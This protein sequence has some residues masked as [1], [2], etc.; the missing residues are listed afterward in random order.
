VLVQGG[1]LNEVLDCGKKY[2]AVVATTI[3]VWGSSRGVSLQEVQRLVKE[4]DGRLNI[5]LS[6]KPDALTIPRLKELGVARISIGPTL[7][8]KAMETLTQEAEKLLTA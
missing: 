7:Q 5:L 6:G 3:F 8:L 2:L 1:T 4:F